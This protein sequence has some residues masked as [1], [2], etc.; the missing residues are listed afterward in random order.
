VTGWHTVV[1]SP[2]DFKTSLYTYGPSYWRYTVYT[3]F[4]TFWG[5]GSYGQVYVNQG[6]SVRG[7]HAVLLIGWDDAKQAYLCKNSWGDR[8]GPN[9]DGT[10]WIAYSGHANNLGFGMANFSVT[11]SYACTVNSDCDDGDLCTIDACNNGGTP[12][13]SC[14]HTV[15]PNCTCGNGFCD[16]GGENCTTCPSDCPSGSSGGTCSACFKGK[17]DGACNPAKEGPTCSDCAASWC[18]G[19]GA[20]SVG[21]TGN[22]PVDCP[23]AACGNGICDAGET[24]C[25]CP[26]DCGPVPLSEANWCNNGVDDDCDGAIDCADDECAGTFACTCWKKGV[27][28]TS[29]SQCCSN[30]CRA[31]KCQ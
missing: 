15:D 1:A 8:G 7:G 29:A 9:G 20:C 25:S 26:D 16:G 23:P 27:A 6:G 17:C 13:A 30:K 5:S 3:D 10:F 22:C 19:D 12:Q 21:E 31:G 4:D 14:S 24:P 28:C 18:C 2:A 11:T